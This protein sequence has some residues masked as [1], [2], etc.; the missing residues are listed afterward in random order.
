MNDPFPKNPGDDPMQGIDKYKYFKKMLK[1]CL[2]VAF[3]FFLM[4]GVIG[5]CIIKSKRGDSQQIQS[6][7]VTLDNFKKIE[8]G[9]TL[10][11][12]VALIG[13][14]EQVSKSKQ[15]RLEASMYSWTSGY[16]GAN[17]SVMFQNGKVTNK[18][19]IGLD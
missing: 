11:E 19:Q 12:V 10:D 4:L 9:M 8:M 16:L 6:G 14:G 15:G 18:A 7:A 13:H 5:S 3:A 17:C 2:W 1:K